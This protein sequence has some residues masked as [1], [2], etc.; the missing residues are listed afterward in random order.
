MKTIPIEKQEGN[1]EQSFGSPVLVGEVDFRF[2]AS[3]HRTR[4]SKYVIGEYS[5]GFLR[6][7][8]RVPAEGLAGPII[9]LETPITPFL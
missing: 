3:K 6:A 7:L 4:R 8:G 5:A 2:Q 1:S 9:E